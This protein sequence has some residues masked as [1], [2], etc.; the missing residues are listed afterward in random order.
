MPTNDGRPLVTCVMITGKSEPRRRLANLAAESFRR[1]TYGPRELLVIN[2]SGEPW[3]EGDLRKINEVVIDRQPGRTLG[4]LRNMAFDLAAGDLLLQWDDD[5]WHGRGRIQTQVAAW[6]ETGRPNVLRRE[7][8]GL[9]AER[10][11]KVVDASHWRAGGFVG[12][13]LHPR[14]VAARYPSQPKAEDLQFAESLGKESPIE[15][16]DNDARHYVRLFHGC[17]TWPREHYQNLVAS[18]RELHDFERREFDAVMWMIDARAATRPAETV[19]DVAAVLGN[20]P[21]MNRGSAAFATELIRRNRL[22][23]VLEIGCLHGVS[24]CYLAAAV[25]PLEGSVTTVDV[26]TSATYAPAVEDTLR[27]C[28][29]SAE[30]L[31]APNGSLTALP[32]LLSGGRQYDLI[33]IDGAHDFRSVAADF[34]HAALLLR[35]HGWLILDDATNKDFPGVAEAISKIVRADARFSQHTTRQNWHLCRRTPPP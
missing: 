25:R 22:R 9:V 16:V 14:S 8:V 32:D 18:G 15:A 13:I 10:E 2:D 21:W 30:I 1:Q 3:I 5:D 19:D 6:Q 35:R 20:L 11:A 27:A 29:L 28:G 23:D 4:D 33:L 24:T 34:F 12:T 31:R 26:P 17:N 7:I